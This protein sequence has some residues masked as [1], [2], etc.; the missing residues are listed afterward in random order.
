MHWYKV[1]LQLKD[2]TENIDE[3]EA[4]VVVYARNPEDAEKDA[5]S[6]ASFW[7]NCQSEDYK[8]LNL[9]QVNLVPV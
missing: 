4:A 9:V 8:V 5:R 7:D 6:M 1:S 3:D 2:D